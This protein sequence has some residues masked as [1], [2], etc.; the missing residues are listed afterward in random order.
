MKIISVTILTIFLSQLFPAKYAGEFL[1]INSDIRS[2]GMGNCGV[3]YSESVSS[4]KLNPANILNNIKMNISTMYSSLYGNPLEPLANYNYLGFSIPFSTEGAA[5]SLSWV[6][7]SID[8]ISYFPKYG[9]AERFHEIEANNGEPGDI[10]HDDYFTDREDAIFLTVAKR[11]ETDISLGW[12]YFSFPLKINLGMNVKF[13][14]ISIFENE[15]S[16][17]GFDAGTTLKIG[18]KKF[19][20][21][22]AAEDLRIGF[23][24]SD[25]NKTGISWSTTAQDAIPIRYKFG[26]SYPVVIKSINS[27]FI[28]A[29]DYWSDYDDKNVKNYGFEYDYNNLI[30][31]RVG[32][33]DGNKFTAG[34]G[35]FYKGFTLDYA[36]MDEEL[37]AV[38]K[39]GLG[40]SF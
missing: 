3:S 6:R 28:A 9:D 34:T 22:R 17:I 37:G 15:A 35:V 27:T 4:F 18:L 1:L 13:I 21:Y 25:F 16:G 14:N 20:N 32:L 31:L 30:K 26:I 38:N 10:N 12:D 24:V 40:Y 2:L 7:L 33:A 39:I 19:L 5:V 11:I 29:Y 36:F 23:V 8:D